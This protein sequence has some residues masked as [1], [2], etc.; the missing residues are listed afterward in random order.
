MVN[1][2]YHRYTNYNSDELLVK[3]NYGIK[4]GINPFDLRLKLMY[5]RRLNENLAV[6]VN[7]STGFF[8]QI[9]PNIIT[10]SKGMKEFSVGVNVQ[11]TLFRR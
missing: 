3:N 7:V 5:Q 2:T 1:S 4:E 11:Y 6:G 10:N 8:N 9:D